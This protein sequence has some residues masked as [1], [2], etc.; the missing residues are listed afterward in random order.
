MVSFITAK[1]ANNLRAPKQEIKQ[2]IVH[3][4]NRIL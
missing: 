2:I 1:T 4:Y 3:L